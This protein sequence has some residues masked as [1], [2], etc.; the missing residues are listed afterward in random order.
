MTRLTQAEQQLKASQ[1]KLI[2]KV[3]KV[4]SQI[5][6]KVILPVLCI[7]TAVLATCMKSSVKLNVSLYC[8]STQWINYCD[9][10]ILLVFDLQA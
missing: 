5:Y 6:E 9:F 3:L 8:H 1:T 2:E 4:Q 7:Q 10:W